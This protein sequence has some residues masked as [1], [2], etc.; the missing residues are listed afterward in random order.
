MSIGR[1]DGDVGL[2]VGRISEAGAGTGGEA[3]VGDETDVVD[4]VNVF[5]A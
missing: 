3:G 1:E 4:W 2:L 5:L